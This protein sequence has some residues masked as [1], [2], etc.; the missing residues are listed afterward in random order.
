[1]D[2]GFESSLFTTPF[3][4]SNGV[5]TIYRCFNGT[6]YYISCNKYAVRINNDLYKLINV[7]Y[8]VH[9]LDTL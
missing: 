1:M 7:V 6:R 4:I 2:V 9:P 8:L 5:L 3:D